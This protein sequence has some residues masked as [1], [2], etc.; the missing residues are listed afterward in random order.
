MVRHARPDD[1]AAPCAA[2]YLPHVRDGVASLEGEPPSPE[3]MARRIGAV[4]RTHPW[5][6]AEREGAVVGYA[7]ASAHHSRS[8]YRWAADVA[9]YV[10]SDHQRKGVGRE[11]YET[12]FDLLRRQGLRIACAGVTLPNDASVGLHEGLG[13]VPVGIYRD[14]GWKFGAWRNVG[15]WQLRLLP[16][17]DG[18]P[19]EPGPPARLEA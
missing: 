5:L 18:R 11:L 14:I 13:F 8:A 7:Y 6:V 15:W 16:S 4:S 17:D 2:I 1:D 9:V 10:D 12:L 3:E 19:A